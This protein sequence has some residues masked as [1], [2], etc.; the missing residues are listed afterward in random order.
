MFALVDCNNFYASCERVFRPDLKTQ[1]VVILSNNDG[2]V[3]ARSNEAK[4]LGIPMGAPA[5]QYE[6]LFKKQQVHVFSSNF[7]LY[8]DMSHRVMTVL[9]SF[10]S[11]MEVYSI[12]EAFLLEPAWR[13]ADLLEYGDVMRKRVLSWT[14]IPISVGFAPT[15]TLS[16]VANHIAKKFPEKTRGVYLI[17]TEERRVK[18][19]KWLPVEEVWGVGRRYARKLQQMGVK[20]AYDFTRLSPQ[21]VRKYFSVVGVR[22]QKEL[23]GDSV[24]GL[25]VS[26]PRKNIATT[27]TFETP[28]LEFEQVRER[29]ATFAVVCAE[30]LRQQHST[31][32]SLMVFVRTNSHRADLPQYSQQAVVKMPYASSSSIELVQYATEGLKQI[33]KTG[34]QY[35]KAG[36][37]VQDI[38]PAQD[39]QMTL[40]ED[41]NDKHIP[42]MQVLDQLNNTYGRQKVKLGSQD[43]K[44]TWKMRQ[45]RLSPRYTTQLSEIITVHC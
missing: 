23:Q 3:I 26:Q 29:I 1:P 10:C 28:Y 9:E 33:F 14:G 34:Y 2:C 18:A 30:K 36:V 45:E 16:K 42:L 21:Q 8:G 20:T 43:V 41:R 25:E 40:F 7:A 37:V 15:K 5:Y 22:L 17:D 12:D 27:R 31:C 6:S 32:H 13:N 24:H 39:R 44:R 4:A 11:D 38:R 19:L 35:K